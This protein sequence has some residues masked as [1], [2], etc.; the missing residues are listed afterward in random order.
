M[1]E[2][3][4]FILT[5]KP[6]KLLRFTAHG[7]C[8]NQRDTV[9]KPSH[10][11]PEGA[12]MAV[13][14][15]TERHTETILQDLRQAGLRVTAQRVALLQAL[16]HVHGHATAETLQLT[17]KSSGVS[18]PMPTVYAVLADLVRVGLVGEVKGEGG[19]LRF[20]ANVVPHHHLACSQCGRLVDIPV[21]EVQSGKPV[22]LANDYG[23]N[24]GTTDITFRGTCPTCRND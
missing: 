19:A 14:L 1:T 15:D 11:H 22:G 17:A 20:D 16:R 9:S 3:D 13:M 12:N 5:S 24:I 23:W 7:V 2:P 21:A 8:A 10:L 4:P 18:I 6:N